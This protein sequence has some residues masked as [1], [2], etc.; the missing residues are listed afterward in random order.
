VSRPLPLPTVVMQMTVE[1]LG[2]R[3]PTWVKDQETSMC[4]RCTNTFTMFRWRHHC[5]ACGLVSC[6]EI[7]FLMLMCDIIINII[8][9]INEKINVA[10][11]GRTA[12]TR[13][14]HKKNKSRENVVSNSTEEEKIVMKMTAR[15][16]MSSAAA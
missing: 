3:A 12:R 10:F 15:R 13:N 4:M 16:A 14:S 6:Y 2:N 5:R 9:I 1:E 11:S 7:D 8:I